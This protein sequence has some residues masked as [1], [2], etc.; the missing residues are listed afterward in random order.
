[1][2]A[3]IRVYDNSGTLLGEF[4]QL[5]ALSFEDIDDRER[6]IC[7]R[8]WSGAWY[9]VTWST[10]PLGANYFFIIRHDATSVRRELYAFTGRI[11]GL[12]LLIS[13]FV[14]GVTMLVLGITVIVP[15]L[16]LR[17][18]LINAGDALSQDRCHCDFY[19]LSFRRQDELG[20]VMAAFNQMFDRVVK[21]I[22]ER[23]Q[24]E[25]VAR[26]ERDKSERLLLNILP[27]PI[28][29]QLKNGDR[30]IADGF[31]EA[32][33]LFA[34]IVGFTGISER[35]SPT[36]LV[37]LLNH[38]FSEFD[39]LSEIHGLEKIK[40]IGDAY[41][42]V[43]GLPT[44]RGDHATAM[45]NMALDM[46]AAIA[47]F[48]LERDEAVSLRIGINTGPVIAGVIGTKKFIY[49]LW[50][51]AVNT[52]SRMES[53]GIAGCIQVSEATY[54]CLHPQFELERRGTIR[55]KGK[56]EMTTYLLVGRKVD[57]TLSRDRL[58]AE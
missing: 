21:E 51:D 38:I 42:V 14:T 48:N 41:M 9:D 3:G 30:N 57:N 44:P 43:G 45:A 23:Q 37:E 13:A 50:G 8:R 47:K 35:V 27:E 22:R 16:R 53:H 17:D 25:A 19:S 1:V 46:Q 10:R 6:A 15:I 34:D 49:D 36:R 29:E 5:P 54:R 58:Q 4:G 40:T 18:D 11:A 12:V 2:I 32:T 7:E 52:A 39:R 55:V 33:I 56:G 26:T 28:A 20:E 24:A 31:S